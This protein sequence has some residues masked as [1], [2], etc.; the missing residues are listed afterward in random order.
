MRSKAERSKSLKRIALILPLAIALIA[1]SNPGFAS[2]K[3][4]SDLQILGNARAANAR[5]EFLLQLKNA[6]TRTPNLEYH[7]DP[8]ID[9]AL[10]TGIK[11]DT[12]LSADFWASLRPIDQKVVVYIASTEN[13]KFLVDEI[14][15]NSTP[16]GLFG[17]WLG[18]KYLQ[19][20]M[21]PHGFFGGGAPAFDKNDNPVFMVYAPNGQ[22]LGN[23]FWTQTTSHEFVH[24][25][26]RY[27]MGGNM[28]PMLGWVIE[29]QADY[30]GANFAT[31]NS[32]EAFASYWIQLIY[33]LARPDASPKILGWN[34]KQFIDWF[35]S[36]ETTL[37]PE[38]AGDIPVENYVVGAIASQYLY[39]T[40]GYKKVNTYYDKLGK[41]MPDCGD[42]DST[43]HVKCNP[44]RQKAFKEAFGVSMAEF[45]PKV[46]A[47]I[48]TEIAWAKKNSST[49]Q[50]D[51][52]KIAPSPWSN[53]KPQP[54]YV[55][56]A[57]LGPISK[58]GNPTLEGRAGASGSSQFVDPY[59]P[60]IAAPGR[61]CLTPNDKAILYGATM[62][63]VGTTTAAKWTLDPGQVVGPAPKP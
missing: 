34:Q 14:T 55:A 19:A 11:V 22:G 20:Q 27:L 30:I 37:A 13:F 53:A 31:R 63:C 3:K 44:S 6:S 56:P 35:K 58:Y 42:G 38:K 8:T 36:K 59:P 17:D 47:H 52:L 33:S 21:E 25:T 16:E 28:S 39:G 9:P 46:A 48:V 32:T 54:P 50:S 15:P 62:T 2:A 61:S 5:G 40:Y 12:A 60:N 24:V 43:T 18:H 41:I 45:Y 23:G 4:K 49:Y 1:P 51:L 57:N 29:G 26:Q 7:I 10:L